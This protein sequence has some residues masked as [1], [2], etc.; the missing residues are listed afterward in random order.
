MIRFNITF[1]LCL[2][3]V[4]LLAQVKEG[5]RSM[6]QGNQNCFMLRVS[7][8]NKKEVEKLWSNYQKDY[9]AKKPKRNRKTKEYF[10]D[11]AKIKDVSDNTIDIYSVLE[12]DGDHIQLAVWFDLGGAFLSS[13]T[14]GKKANE[15]KDWLMGFDQKVKVKAVEIEMDFEEDKLK[16]MR[17]EMSK[18][19]KE[20]ENL[21]K[22]IEKYK[23]KIVD[24]E[25]AIK[26]NAIAQ[27]QKTNAIFAQE[28]AIESVKDKMKKIK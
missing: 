24:A 21:L 26:N 1:I 23:Q 25:E 28:K 5:T 9:K 4:A 16:N 8:V 6:S 19:E 15:A 2:G 14:H 7:D 20:K 11:N 17:K 3:A 13:N 12:E 10:A 22:D 18:L 27:E